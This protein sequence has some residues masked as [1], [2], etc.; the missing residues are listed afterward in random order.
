MYFAPKTPPPPPIFFCSVFLL[1]CLIYRSW[2]FC[3][4][5]IPLIRYPSD[6]STLNEDSVRSRRPCDRLEI[7]PTSSQLILPRLSHR[8]SSSYLRRE[9]HHHTLPLRISLSHLLIAPPAQRQVP[10][11]NAHLASNLLELEAWVFAFEA[12]HTDIMNECLICRSRLSAPS[13]SL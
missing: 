7:H 4:F 2:L 12:V 8:L 5:P 6:A 10:S 1:G 11:P 3:T 13:H 9:H